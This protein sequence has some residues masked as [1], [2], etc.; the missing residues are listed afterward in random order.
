MS[1][2]AIIISVP[3]WTP[4][5][6]GPFE[7]KKEASIKLQKIINDEF[8]EEF[9]LYKNE[10]RLRRRKND[11]YAIERKGKVLT[12]FKLLPLNPI[13]ELDT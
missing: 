11:T 9:A 12:D 5:V 13:E 2:Y 1:Q 3:G 7:S 4:N 8:R 10:I 6:Y